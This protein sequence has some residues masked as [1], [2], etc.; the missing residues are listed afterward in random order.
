MTQVSDKP[1]ERPRL[2]EAREDRE[3]GTAG[4][5][6]AELTRL[7]AQLWTDDGD[8]S[9]AHTSLSGTKGGDSI[10]MIE[11]IAEHLAPRIQAVSQWPLQAVLY[12]PR[13][14]RINARVRREQGAW[15]IDLEA[16][17]DATARW[18]SG[19]RQPCEDRLAVAL[20]QPVSLHLSTVGR[21]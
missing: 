8:G 12:V 7:F 20:G 14:G 13:L 6:P 15:S 5:V 17:E 21:A 11:A 10:A 19:V 3:S 9:G 4:V 1:A 18:L 2:R 16:Q